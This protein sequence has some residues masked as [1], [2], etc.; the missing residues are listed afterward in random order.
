MILAFRSLLFIV[1]MYGLMVVIGLLALP[2]LIMPEIF[3]KG[4]YSLWLKLVFWGLRVL[5]GLRFEVHGHDNI[6]EGGFLIASKHHSMLDVL[7][8]WFIF[9]NPVIILKQQLAFLPVFGWYALKTGNIAIN[10]KAGTKALRHMNQEAQKRL[11]EGRPV[12]IFPEGTRTTPG[13][14]AE[15]KPGVAALYKN[16]HVPCLPVAHNGGLFWPAHGLI[17]KPGLIRFE[18][19]PPIPPGLGRKDFMETLEERLEAACKELL[20]ETSSTTPSTTKGTAS[21]G[22]PSKDKS[23]EQKS[24]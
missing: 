10:R 7:V 16:L 20:P 6:P 17:R 12:L 3:A 19:L 4:V 1:W 24:L 14:P 5:C 21:P 9:N 23:G 13:D 2:S 22:E 8:P 11:D 18:I 15:Y